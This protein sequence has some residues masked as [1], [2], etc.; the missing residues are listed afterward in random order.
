MKTFAV[1]TVLASVLSTAAN[2]AAAA[3][4]L[5]SPSQFLGDPL[6]IYV[7]SPGVIETSELEENPYSS[8]S[9]SAAQAVSTDVVEPTSSAP[10]TTS[11]YVAPPAASSA[12]V[13]PAP[14]SP[15]SPTPVVETQPTTGTSTGDIP[16]GQ[17]N[18]FNVPSGAVRFP[19]NYNNADKVVPITPNEKNGGWA[20]SPDQVCKPGTWCPYACESG[21]YAAQYDPAALLYNGAGSMNGGLY[22]DANGVLT[23]PNSGKA[24]CEPGMFNAY[25]KNTLGQSV[26][27]CQTVYPGNEAM[28][29]PTVAQG[30]GGTMPLN[31]VPNTYWLGTSAQ[32]YVNL[33]GSTAA[34]CIWGTAASPI[35]NWGA[36]IFGAGQGKD[37]N[38]YISVQYN[39][40]YLSAGFKA[41][42]TYNVKIECVSGSCNFPTGGE[43]KCEQGKCSVDNGC[44]VTLTGD[45]KANFVLY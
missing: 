6:F 19:W 15:A 33:A 22:A 10:S 11:V 20:M 32:F 38:T 31:V 39:P 1:L 26:S 16:D 12:Y 43:C 29:I 17:G 21:Y 27:A 41:T 3:D 37:G 14:S 9:S 25:I 13:Q 34:Q 18:N 7:K 2:T 23:K 45:A 42:D 30:G 35:G 36:F 5:L 8:P 44:T 24:F 40:L 28:L 4:G